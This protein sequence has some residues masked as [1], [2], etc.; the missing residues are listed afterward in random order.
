MDVITAIEEKM[1]FVTE[2]LIT[3]RIHTLHVTIVYIQ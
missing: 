3:A 2:F 1:Y